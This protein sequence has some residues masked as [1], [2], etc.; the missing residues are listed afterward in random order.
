MIYGCVIIKAKLK[1][2]EGKET[3]D[4]LMTEHL[5]CWPSEGSQFPKLSKSFKSDA[6][7]T[8]SFN[9]DVILEAPS[10]DPAPT[11]QLHSLACFSEDRLLQNDGA[12]FAV[13]LQP[14][15]K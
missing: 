2:P 15:G 5:I 8:H 13:S 3:S 11:W 14:A 6:F 7:Y 1:L 9:W 10:P 12:T 4:E